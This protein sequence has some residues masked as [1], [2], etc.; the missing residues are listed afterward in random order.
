MPDNEYTSKSKQKGD[1]SA[2]T[3]FTYSTPPESI[4]MNKYHIM[5]IIQGLIQKPKGTNWQDVAIPAAL[6]IGALLAL[7]TTTS[8]RDF[9]GMPAALWEAIVFI[10]A[11]GSFV[12]MVVQGVR[13]CM[14]LRRN[15]QKTPEQVYEEIT[16][17]VNED[18]RK[19][20]S[21]TEKK[22]ID[23]GDSQI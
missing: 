4:N 16:T 13:L 12:W 10:I 3:G 19:L 15:P 18:W 9:L 14:Y 17:R 20:I 7:L 23:N 5:Y 1:V 22:D 11:V 21:S 2:G 8:F 6:F